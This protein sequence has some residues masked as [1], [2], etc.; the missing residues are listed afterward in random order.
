MKENTKV[1]TIFLFQN[2]LLDIIHSWVKLSRVRWFLFSVSHQYNQNLFDKHIT[3]VGSQN[4]CKVVTRTH[5]SNNITNIILI[6]FEYYNIC[7]EYLKKFNNDICS[8]SINIVSLTYH[9]YV[10]MN[11]GKKFLFVIF[12][13]Y[14]KSLI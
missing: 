7:D 5:R 2:Y 11:H 14:R 13:V 3:S 12:P 9:I 1:N 10:K 6:L 4:Q 8:D